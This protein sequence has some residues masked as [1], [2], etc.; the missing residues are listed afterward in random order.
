MDNKVKV[1]IYT[2]SLGG[3]GSTGSAGTA[4]TTYTT[5]FDFVN[6]N[7]GIQPGNGQVD[8]PAP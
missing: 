3:E 7:V 4:G 8:F 2:V 6:L 5:R 1:R